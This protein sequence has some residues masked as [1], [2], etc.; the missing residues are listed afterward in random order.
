[1]TRLLQ[2]MA[3]VALTLSATA[4]SLQ[5]QGVVLWTDATGNHNFAD[6]GNWDPIFGY[7]EAN[8][9]VI[10]NNGYANVVSAPPSVAALYVGGYQE[11][12][13]GAGTLN[14]QTGGALTSTGSIYLA[15][16]EGNQGTL[17]ITGGTLTC[18]TLAA[19]S[20]YAG[21]SAGSLSVVNLS[22]G[23]LSLYNPDVTNHIRLAYGANS[24]GVINQT[25][26]ILDLKLGEAGGSTGGVMYIGYASAYGYYRLAGGEFDSAGSNAG[27]GA[28]AVGVIEQL[29]GTIMNIGNYG[30]RI[31]S[32]TNS[33][34]LFNQMGGTVSLDRVLWAGG[35]S[36]GNW[37]QIELGGTIT[38]TP[39]EYTAIAA[40]AA[41]KGYLNLNAGGVL[42]TDD[43]RTYVTNPANGEGF[44]N[45]HGGTLKANA[46]TPDP[47][48]PATH[49]VRMPA[50]IGGIFLGAEGGTIDTD[51][52]DVV[53]SDAVQGL[54]GLG[55]SGFTF[56]GGSGYDGPPVVKIEQLD[57]DVDGQRGWGATAL[58]TVSGGAVTAITVTNPG[59]GYDPDDPVTVTFVGGGPDIVGEASVSAVSMAVNGVDGGLAKKG[60]GMLT[61]AG[62]NTYVGLTDVQAGTLRVTGS[63]AGNVA[64]ADAGAWSGNH[65]DGAAANVAGNLNMSAGGDML[66]MLAALAD[67]TTGTAG[68]DFDQTVVTGSLSLGATS[69][70]TLDFDSLAE[71]DRP[72]AATPNA[73]WSTNHTWTILDAAS[74]SGNFTSWLN[75]TFASGSFSTSLDTLNGDVLLNYVYGP[76]AQI[77]GDTNNDRKVDS[78]DAEKLAQNWGV[79]IGGGN[80]VGDFNGDG[81][82]NAADASILAAN[83]GD[84]TGGESHAVVP[85]PSTLAILLAGLI[86]LATMTRA[87]QSR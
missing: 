76:V 32:N 54:T 24:V 79:Q 81:W 19:S 82:V 49:F 68:V 1:M 37:G 51:G 66:W 38:V 56:T 46:S 59:A 17:N 80:T 84:H 27:A 45:F 75:A 83:W 67:N 40:H 28:S 7:P 21:Y 5:A 62:A 48:D 25:G 34:G 53:I 60:L 23:L 74:V 57:A 14:V 2:T 26:G 44:L 85:E 55:V 6:A 31:G 64:V 9:A 70:L 10:Q 61:L 41:S 18:G 65:A 69:A 78:A 63:L 87:K 71:A 73:F 30:L 43:V 11:G 47:A 52:Y 12:M 35:K 22:S 72:D 3:L 58:A 42:A 33:S 16:G 8:Y 36:S 77:P 13:M 29:T 86:G 39:A 50:A 15:E 4:A 20:V